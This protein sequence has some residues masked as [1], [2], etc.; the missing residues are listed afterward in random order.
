MVAPC[1]N[2]DRR[3]ID[4]HDVCKDYRKYHA[5]REMIQKE[6]QKQKVENPPPRERR[7]IKK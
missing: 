6:R 7:F 3:T 2:C 5:E 4:C 1:K